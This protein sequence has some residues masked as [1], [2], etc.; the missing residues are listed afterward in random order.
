M[1]ET[2]KSRNNVV[3][4]VAVTARRLRRNGDDDGDDD[5]VDG[6]RTP[7]VYTLG[8]VA[9]GG[10]LQNCLRLPVWRAR[11]IIESRCWLE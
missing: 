3:H 10:C 5:G 8:A 11:V 1:Y 6:P 4:G 2:V 9:T 7:G